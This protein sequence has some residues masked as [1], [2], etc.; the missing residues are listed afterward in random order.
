M[1]RFFVVLL[2]SALGC[3]QTAA[4]KPTLNL[5][6]SDNAHKARAM[7]DQ[8]V[9]ALGGNAYLT[10]QN[11]FEYGRYYP[12]YHGRTSTLGIP[13][14]YYVQYPDKDRFE[15]LAEKDIHVIPGTIDIGGIKSKKSVVVLIHNGMKGYETTY[16]GTAPQDPEQ[17]DNYLRRRQH[18]LDWVFR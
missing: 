11:R 17:L 7:L 13:Y 3:A 6:D 10:Y 9:Q 1:H 5:N 18:S 8:A 2:F 4:P 15:L 12:L 16:K 14:N